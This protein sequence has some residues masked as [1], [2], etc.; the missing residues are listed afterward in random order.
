[1]AWTI[2][3]P[4]APSGGDGGIPEAPTD[5]QQ[6]GRQNSSWTPITTIEP[7]AGGLIDIVADNVASI[8]Y[9]IFKQVLFA[10]TVLEEKE[11]R[12]LGSLGY[13]MNSTNRSFNLD[14]NIDGSPVS[15]FGSVERKDSSDTAPFPI[16][17]NLGVLPVGTEVS[18]TFGPEF[19][20]AS[21]TIRA[22]SQVEILGG[23]S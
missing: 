18:I 14:L 1:M 23:A 6:Y 20:P 10:F 16:Y 8:P 9:S 7:T 17:R 3:D 2:V 19:F 13:S 21:A 12:V 15:F 4:N 5:G 11:Y 22:G